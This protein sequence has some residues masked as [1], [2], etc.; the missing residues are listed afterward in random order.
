MQSQMLRTRVTNEETKISSTNEEIQLL[1]AELV[2]IEATILEKKLEKQV[3]GEKLTEV[4]NEVQILQSKISEEDSRKV[5][6]EFQLG[7]R[8]NE[9]ESTNEEVHVLSVELVKIQAKKLEKK[10]QKQ[11]LEEKLTKAHKKVENLQT[12]IYEEDSTKVS[13]DFQLG[14]RQNEIEELKQRIDAQLEEIKEQETK[15]QNMQETLE[16]L[17]NDIDG[18]E[19]EIQMTEMKKSDRDKEVGMVKKLLAEAGTKKQ[20]L[21]EKLSAIYVENTD[22]EKQMQSKKI[23]KK[24]DGNEISCEPSDINNKRKF[25]K[26]SSACSQNSKRRVVEDSSSASSVSTIV[27][28]VSKCARESFM[29]DET[30]SSENKGE[31]KKES[32]ASASA[33][34]KNSQISPIV[35]LSQPSTSTEQH[36]KGASTETERDEKNESVVGQG[37][38]AKAREREKL[39]QHERSHEP[40]ECSTEEEQN[41]D[42][43]EL[44]LEKRKETKPLSV[45]ERLVKIAKQGSI[46]VELM[47]TNIQ[48]RS[49]KGDVTR[50]LCRYGRVIDNRF[51]QIPTSEST[52]SVVVTMDTIKADT[53][54]KEWLSQVQSDSGRLL[55]R[56]RYLDVKL[57][58]K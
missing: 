38:Y 31:S 6:L 44:F 8:Q 50:A 13:L 40:G 58:W 22:R 10:S 41:E 45:S 30:D 16:I 52:G 46:K 1:S 34:Q 25:I 7:S 47:V 37:G 33:S 20:A 11:L 17:R 4:H 24:E 57:F 55:L 43:T 3:L 26:E 39:G 21:I 19:K 36:H 56:N 23:V 14:A 49:D 54:T 2:K 27:I 5:S 28:D 35:F 32:S 18:F 15:R 12:K 48:Y 53:K 42:K 51:V 9:I 29:S